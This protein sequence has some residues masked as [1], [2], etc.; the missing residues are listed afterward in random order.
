ME[1]EWRRRRGKVERETYV[2]LAA[3]LVGL[4]DDVF[5]AKCFPLERF[6]SSDYVHEENTRRHIIPTIVASIYLLTSL[7]LSSVMP[8]MSAFRAR[9]F[10]RG[11]STVLI[12]SF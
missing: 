12:S 10:A 2:N 6:S 8:E 4:P 1:G 3:L 7:R 5:P 11:I 9:V